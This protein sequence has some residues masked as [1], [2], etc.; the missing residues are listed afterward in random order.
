[1]PS[2]S[3]LNKDIDGAIVAPRDDLERELVQIWED[4]LE[5]QP[6]GIH[7]NF[8]ELGGHSLLAIR[9]IS[10]INQRFEKNL[11]LASVFSSPTVEQMASRIRQDNDPGEWS[12]VV[13]IKTGG[14]RPPFFCIHGFGGGVLDYGEL[15]RLL[16]EEYPFYGIQAKGVDG[17]DGAHGQ[18]EEMAEYY[19]DAIREVQPTGPYYL[20]GYCFGGVVAYEMAYQLMA[21]GEEVAFLGIFEGYAPLRTNYRS[22]WNPQNAANFFKNVPFWLDDY[23]DLGYEHM[24]ARIRRKISNARKK[25]SHFGGV[26]VQIKLE[27]VLDDTSYLPEDRRN[28]LETHLRAHMSYVPP[29]YPG[30]IT[31]FRVKGLSLF[32]SFDPLMG[33]GKLAAGGVNIRIIDGAHYN[34]FMLPHV[35]SLA[36]QLRDCLDMAYRQKDIERNSTKTSM[37]SHK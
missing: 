33:W 3:Q 9:L 10:K 2:P 15:A 31:L 27:D 32:R 30:Q 25:F 1:L 21:Q 5:V 34:I 4:V 29:T 37:V 16:G 19:I 11:P 7:H 23:L 18:I 24:L 17:S 22:M 20:G 6:I 14:S 12:P 35:N 26:P 8:F 13:P 36:S 28:L